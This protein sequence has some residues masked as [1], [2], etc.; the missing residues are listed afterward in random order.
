M[1]DEPIT[2]PPM[3]ANRKARISLILSI[4]TLT[5]VCVG[6]LPIPFTM[7]IC[8]PFAF[9]LGV[10]AMIYGILSLREIKI[11]NEGGKWMAQTGIIVGGLD[12]VALACASI[13]AIALIDFLKPYIEQYVQ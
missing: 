10:A 8:Y 9:F 1:T 5:F 11:S 12:I 3:P 13:V 7:L 4:I 2:L 6:L